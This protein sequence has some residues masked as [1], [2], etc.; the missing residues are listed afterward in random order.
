MNFHWFG[1]ASFLLWPRGF[2]RN[3]LAPEDGD[4]CSN[5][6]SETSILQIQDGASFA[7]MLLHAKEVCVKGTSDCWKSLS[8]YRRQ[9][10][11][12]ACYGLVLADDSDI[13]TSESEFSKIW[14]T[15]SSHLRQ[16]CLFVQGMLCYVLFYLRVT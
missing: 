10:W 12:K 8:T 5:D 14:K 4:V 1:I 15:D 13:K 16:P 7:S 6:V 11:Q 9:M 2:C 3:V